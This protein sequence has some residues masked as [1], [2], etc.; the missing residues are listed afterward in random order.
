MSLSVN[1]VCVWHVEVPIHHLPL[2]V[3]E[4]FQEKCVSSCIHDP[5]I[6]VLTCLHILELNIS[7]ESNVVT[8]VR[9]SFRRVFA[10]MFI[11]SH[12]QSNRPGSLANVTG[13]R[14][15]PSASTSNSG[16]RSGHTS[17]KSVRSSLIARSSQRSLFHGRSENLAWSMWPL[18]TPRCQLLH[19]VTSHSDRA[20]NVILRMRN[21]RHWKWYD[22][23]RW[24]IHASLHLEGHGNLPLGTLESS[25]HLAWR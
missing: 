15:T 11:V 20:R 13:V 18:V 16:Y 21:L 9:A 22:L 5:Y 19:Q 23:T 8:S 14:R 10:P 3:L 1:L 7:H 17:R 25:V 24:A 12:L 2:H 6:S 4:E